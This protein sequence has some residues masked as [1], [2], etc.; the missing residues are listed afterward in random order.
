MSTN[1][2]QISLEELRVG[3]L[4]MTPDGIKEV[5]GL[6]IDNNGDPVD[7]EVYVLNPEHDWAYDSYFFNQIRPIP[8][9]P[10]HLLSH[11]DGKPNKEP[12]LG[13]TIRRQKEGDEV[14][15]YRKGLHM[16][17]DIKPTGAWLVQIQG[18]EFSYACRFDQLDYHTLQNWY[19]FNSN[20]TELVFKS[21][22]G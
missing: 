19:F 11:I 2:Q 7:S 3:N 8:I 9:E 13:M 18:K 4:I 20:K 16:Y 10:K 14:F 22:E 21:T 12:N 1:T 5:I 17:H 6:L 15:Y